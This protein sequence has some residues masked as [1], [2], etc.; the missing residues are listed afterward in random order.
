ML[1]QVAILNR[2]VYLFNLCRFKLTELRDRLLALEN[3]VYHVRSSLEEV[4][5]SQGQAALSS[6]VTRPE[7][8]KGYEVTEATSRTSTQVLG[9]LV[10]DRNSRTAPASLIRDMKHY[11]LGEK[12][13][14]HESD[15]S[16]DIVAKGIISD[17][18]TQRLLIG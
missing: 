11:I 7:V 3:S 5:G 10:A 18:M 9:P 13:G 2:G 1:S 4:L 8:G 17:G 15:A 16:E 14:S 6:E 12:K